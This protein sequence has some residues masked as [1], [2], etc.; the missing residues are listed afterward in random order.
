MSWSMANRP[1][2]HIG[3]RRGDAGSYCT[4]VIAPLL[5]HGCYCPVAVDQELLPSINCTVRSPARQC[6]HSYARSGQMQPDT[7]GVEPLDMNLA[8]R[9][10]VGDTLTRTAA[11][12]GDRTAIVHGERQVTYQELDRA[13]TRLANALLDTG[14]QRQQPVAMAMANSIEFVTAYYACAKAG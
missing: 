3:Y 2:M 10:S 7:S 11:M 4:A 8:T 12:F 14:L 6:H 13:S 1:H 9:A 5:L